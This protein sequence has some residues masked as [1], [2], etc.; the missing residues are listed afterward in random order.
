MPRSQRHQKLWLVVDAEMR[1]EWWSGGV[2]Q[3]LGARLDT[4]ARVRIGIAIG[5]CLPSVLHQE[6]GTKHDHFPPLDSFCFLLPETPSP[7]QTPIA[8]NGKCHARCI[9]RLIERCIDS[10]L[11]D[12]YT[13]Q[14][15]LSVTP[16]G[17]REGRTSRAFMNNH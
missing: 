16:L 2:M 15:L 3:K 5:M 4:Y 17:L 8:G 11:S 6:S 12:R 9:D 7:F 13:S 10:L 14:L 1:R